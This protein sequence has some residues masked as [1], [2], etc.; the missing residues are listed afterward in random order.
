MPNYCYLDTSVVVSWCCANHPLQE[1]E[2]ISRAKAIDSILAA[3]AITLGISELT[4]VELY[5]A[6]ARRWRMSEDPEFDESSVRSALERILSAVESGRCTVVR[7]PPKVT[8]HAMVLV[9]L[10]AR[11]HGVSFKAW[12]ATHLVT[13]ARW[14][15]RVNAKVK[16]VTAD[17][18]FRTFLDRFSYFGNWVELELV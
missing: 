9:T 16:I 2:D 3:P 14:A 12:D 18:D 8:E 15:R 10:A 6:L 17:N 5:D 1:A 4:I 13:A 7:A 11:D